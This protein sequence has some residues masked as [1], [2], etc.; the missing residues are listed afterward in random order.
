MLW[1]LL[2][3]AARYDLAQGRGTGSARKSLSLALESRP[4]GERAEVAMDFDPVLLARLQFAFTIIFH[5]IFPSFTIGLSA[6]IATLGVHL[7]KPEETSR[8]GLW[9]A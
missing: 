5:I 8:P 2:G 7:L 6:Y 9:H 4:E 3:G 1:I